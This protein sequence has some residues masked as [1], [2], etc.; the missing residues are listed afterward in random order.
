[1]KRIPPLVLAAA[2]LLAGCAGWEVVRARVITID[3][4]EAAKIVET[5]GIFIVDVRPE[6]MF[7]EGHLLGARSIP[8]RQL[9]AR[10]AELPEDKMAP[11]FVYCRE[12]RSSTMAA[13]LLKQ[14]GWVRVYNLRGGIQAWEAH[15]LPLEREYRE[16]RL[17]VNNPK[18]VLGAGASAR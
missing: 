13:F 16:V 4:L 7:R 3:P 10:L 12:G 14:E 6:R 1:M 5:P 18:A 15:G 11:V 8:Y 2:G 9:F 17:E